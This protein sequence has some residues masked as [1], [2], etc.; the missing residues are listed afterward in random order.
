MAIS[1]NLLQSVLQY[2]NCKTLCDALDKS[3][4][5]FYLKKNESCEEAS[6]KNLSSLLK[7]SHSNINNFIA[8]CEP[9]PFIMPFRAPY[10][11]PLI[12]DTS[13]DTKIPNK[14]DPALQVQFGSAI[15]LMIAMTI[16]NN[17]NYNHFY[18]YNFYKNIIE[19][20]KKA[21]K[22]LKVESKDNLKD[23][24]HSNR[25]N[26]TIYDALIKDNEDDYEDII[27]DDGY[28][29][30]PLKE[31]SETELR[32]I[33]S[34]YGFFGL[35]PISERLSTLILDMSNENFTQLEYIKNRF[36]STFLSID[37]LFDDGVSDFGF[38][39]LR[40]TILK[41]DSNFGII[42][43]ESSILDAQV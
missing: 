27:K 1:T 43:E 23:R 5:S 26:K 34:E 32:H 36:I 29:G 24:K 18:M 42:N 33:V 7:N 31:L 35:E 25:E 21:K 14:Y 2:K 28:D 39:I 15:N 12:L 4:K 19:N 40:N 30:K 3:D 6:L 38:D 20:I 13:F 8:L 16:H 22:R 17:N 9:R 37:Y 41:V 11:P 10:L